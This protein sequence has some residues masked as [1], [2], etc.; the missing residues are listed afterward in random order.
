MRGITP[1]PVAFERPD[2]GLDCTPHDCTIRPGYLFTMGDNRDGS[3]D[4][5]VWGAVPMKYLRGTATVIWFSHDWTQPKL[6][7][8]PFTI[9]AL[10]TDRLFSDVNTEP[11]ELPPA[12]P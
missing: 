12:S 2:S 3:A 8:G 10:R 11:L 1:G 7:L 9:G 4:S 5:R 6:P